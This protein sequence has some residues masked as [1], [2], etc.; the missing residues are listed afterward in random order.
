MH[1]RVR[2]VEGTDGRGGVAGGKGGE[3]EEEEGYSLRQR[4]EQRK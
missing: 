3:V 1:V 2:M 4:A